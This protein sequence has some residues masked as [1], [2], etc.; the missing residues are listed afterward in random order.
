MSFAK[1]TRKV[2]FGLLAIAAI[3]YGLRLS[4][5]QQNAKLT[6]PPKATSSQPS[7]APENSNGGSPFV[8]GERLVYNVSWS[9]FS[10]AARIEME[11]V[12]QG[13]FYG[14]ESYQLRS[15]VETLGQMRSLFG[16]VDNQYT[17]YVSMSSALPHR[18]VSAINQGQRKAE[19]VTV[20]DQSKQKATFSDD[21]TVSIRG[22]TYDLTSIIY[23]LR[24]RPLT[25]GS[26][27]KFTA[28]YEKE[29][30]EVEAIVKGRERIVAQAGSFNAILVKFYPKGKYSS[31]RGQIYI[32][33]DSQRLPVMVKA[34]LPVGEARAE[35]T[36]VTFVSQSA[37]P[38]A[39]LDPAPDAGRKPSR[40]TII[41]GGPGGNGNAKGNGPSE[42]PA[43][44]AKP[45]LDVE[46]APEPK[47]Y[48]FIVGERLNYDISWGGFSSVGKA[49]FEVRQQGMLNGNRVIEFFGE[50]LS[51]GGARTLINVNDQIS[52]LVLMD[53]LLPVKTDLRLREGKRS[54]QSTATYDR[55]RNLM[56]LSGSS[57]TE[58]MPGSYDILS[59]F[60][61]VR[62]AD[63][64]IGMTR[65]FIFYDANNR[66]QLLA[67]RVVKQESIGGPMGT[68]DALQVDVLAP[69][70]AKLLLAQT[71]ISN[72][73]RRLPLYLV[74]RTRFG[75]LRFQM[76]SAV[77]TK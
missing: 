64:K 69:E 49:S 23:G 59:L 72:D 12:G 48:P 20:L 31:F 38:L 71:W 3:S 10:S 57:Q 28:I 53:S 22:G 21:S 45:G 30:I 33:D 35:L 76:V 56:S 6:P 47:N 51:A 61:A 54:K 42:S 34:R 65:E 1:T 73:A 17:S 50:A 7:E 75:E 43:N 18:V 46:S 74:T 29:L 66:P 11:V 16:D 25:D 77:N 67:I 44:G 39:K 9:S 24:L 8:V 41:S 70:P 4:A 62:A 40:P 60:Y 32:S 36:S 68:R 19:A 27:Y 13:Q 15:K 55:S 26:K 37:T 58:L 52:S 5:Q 63:L 14:Q 2:I